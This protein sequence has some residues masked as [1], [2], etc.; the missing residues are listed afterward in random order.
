MNRT[1]AAPLPLLSQSTG[2]LFAITASCALAYAIPY[3]VLFDRV[4]AHLAIVRALGM[5]V[6]WGAGLWLQR[7]NG[8]ALD[9]VRM[10]RPILTI[11][12]IALAAAIWCVLMDWVAFR[13]IIPP[14]YYAFEQQPLGLRLIY[15]SSR[16]FNENVMYRLFLG[17]LLAWVLRIAF[18]KSELA[19]PLSVLGMGLGQILNVA[20]NTAFAG[21]SPETCAWMFLRFVIP[22]TLWGVL[23]IRHGF[24]A[25]EAAAISVHWILQPL[26]TLS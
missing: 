24:I 19:L 6:F 26:I 22:G 18:N 2:L 10:E 8:F 9:T 17:S 11:G 12:A 4:T 3:D 1:S 13:S 14:G 23:Y 21:F 5:L 7:A 25:N 20:V 16:A 15:Y